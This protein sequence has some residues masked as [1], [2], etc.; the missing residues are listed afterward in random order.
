MLYMVT[1]TINIPQMLAYIPAPWILWDWMGIPNLL[2]T[3]WGIGTDE[4]FFSVEHSGTLNGALVHHL[5]ESHWDFNCLVN[6]WLIMVNLWLI[7][8]ITM[9]Y[10]VVLWNNGILNDFPETVGNGKSSQLTFTP[11]FFRGV[12]IPPA[13]IYNII[14]GHVC[15]IIQSPS[16]SLMMGNPMPK[17]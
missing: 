15:S 17:R 3:G 11:S 16:Q 14:K 2:S 6:L 4:A 8:G 5:G 1:F 9:G 10:C 7:I 12:G 13:S